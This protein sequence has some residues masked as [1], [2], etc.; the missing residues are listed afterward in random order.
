[1][2]RGTTAGTT[3]SIA[4]AGA[5]AVIAVALTAE[6]LALAAAGEAGAVPRLARA[7]TSIAA[8]HRRQTSAD[9]VARALAVGLRRQSAGTVAER[10]RLLRLS[11]AAATAALEAVAPPRSAATDGVRHRVRGARAAA[12]RGLAF[13]GIPAYVS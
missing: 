5:G 10:P 1:M 13:A 2:D 7:A 3:A 8:A 4:A 6:V 12:A 9:I 11:E